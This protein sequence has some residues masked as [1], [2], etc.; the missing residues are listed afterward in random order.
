M[1]GSMHITA[2]EAISRGIP[3]AGETHFQ[4]LR[5][6]L[7][8]MIGKGLRRGRSTWYWEKQQ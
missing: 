7:E 5:S 3:L 8:D 2:L 4:R 6:R 1:L